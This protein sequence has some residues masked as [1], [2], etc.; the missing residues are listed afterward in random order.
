[1]RI[2]ID[3]RCFAE[4]RHTGVEEYTRE[5]LREIFQ[6]DRE[7]EYVLFFNSWSVPR[8]DFSW[9]K[10]Y[11]NV[12]LR[13]FRFPNKLLNF[14][15]WY[16]RRPFLDRM[17]G[18][19]DLFFLP[20]QN[21]VSISRRTKLVVTAHDLSF[22]LFP[23]T[24]S[25]K[26]RLWHFFVNFRATAKRADRILAVSRSTAD[27]IRTRYRLPAQKVRV[28][29]SGLHPRFEASSR[30]A[31]ETLSV[32]ER[33]RL[34]YRYILS[35]GTFEPRKNSLALLSAY[36]TL[37]ALGGKAAEA[38]LVLAG[39][40]G[41]KTK[42]LMRRIESSPAREKIHVLGYVPEEDKLALY[43]LASA[44]VYP[45]LYE[46]FGFPPLEALACGVPVIASHSSSL[47]EIVGEAAILIDPYQP[48]EIL[49][50]LQAVLG[51]AS[52]A[53][54]LVRRGEEGRGRLSWRAAAKETRAVFRELA[55][56]A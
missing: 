30:N 10:E 25:F 13:V 16:L 34:P 43:S 37:Q 21:F 22:L 19:V 40:P 1:M 2:G 8:A 17:L 26:Q 51:D 45:S 44:F 28:V 38:H 32:K 41:W 31:L 39:S 4:G 6:Q 5:L 29:Q 7:N 46:G 20:N 56:K 33:Y 54:L 36:E 42:R 24:F 49:Q 50:A 52:L 14:S 15:L 27:D 48:N 35:F 11:P 12:T 3:V 18:R 55:K 9:I 53:S 23:E 47:P